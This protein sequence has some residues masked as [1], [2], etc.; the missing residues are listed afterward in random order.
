MPSTLPYW[1]LSAFYACYFATL[2]VQVPYWTPYLDSLGFR[3]A[4]IGELTA[5]MLLSRIIAPNLWG[6][7]ADH[8]GMRMPIVRL[9]SVGAVLGFSLVFIDQSFWWIAL[10]MAAFSFFWNGALPQFE[11]TTLSYLGTDTH[12]YSRIRLW[13]SVGFIVSVVLLGYLLESQALSIVPV[14]LLILFISIAVVSFSVADRPH[15]GAPVAHTPLLQVVRQ[16]AVLA[17]LAACILMQ[18][19]HGPYYTFYSLYMGSYGY[20]SSAVGILWALGV[21]AEV[22][23]FLIMHRLMFKHSLRA[24]FLTSF[25]L[26]ALRWLM[27]AFLMDNLVLVVIAQT[28]HAASFALYHAVGI[29]LIH[30]HFKGRNQVRGQALYASLSYGVG[31]ALGTLSSGYSWE[32][33]F[34]PQL[35]FTWAALACAIGT[36]LIW[37]WVR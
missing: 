33:P 18:F 37:R 4:E 20:S 26:S 19:S 30:Q 17:L 6:W 34:G 21:I 23:L 14:T 1:R 32:L 11:A 28:L 16:P 24:L 8:S 15:Q 22:G 2:G 31:G 5:I 29:Q 10:S 36:L 9:T 7:I 25:I 27:I 35:T 13:G 12:Q 3:P